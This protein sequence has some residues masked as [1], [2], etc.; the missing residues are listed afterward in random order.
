MGRVWLLVILLHTASPEVTRCIRLAW[1]ASDGFTRVSWTSPGMTE[2]LSLDGTSPRAL[3]CARS[4]MTVLGQ[5][6][7]SQGSPALPKT[8]CQETEVEAASV[9]SRIQK[10]AL[11]RFYRILSVR[12]DPGPAR[13]QSE[14]SKSPPLLGEEREKSV[15]II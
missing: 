7:S 8:R 6:D 2:R 14:R 5:S 4:G 10:L 12:A 13:I 3:G 1:R 9:C 11:H 15:A